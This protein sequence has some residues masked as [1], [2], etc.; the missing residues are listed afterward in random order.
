M[1]LA[2]D[3]GNSNIKL[4]LFDKS[5][6]KAQW[7]L[8]SSDLSQLAELV[9]KNLDAILIASVVPALNPT[10]TRISEEHFSLTPVF[11]DHT[12]PTGL[13]ILYDSPAELGADRIVDAVAAVA[14]YGAPCIVV[15]F[16]TATTFNA[17]NAAGEFLGGAISPGLMTCSEALF[18]RAAKLP[19]V[20]FERPAKVIGASTIASMQSGIYYGYTGLVDGMLERMIAE[21]NVKPRVIATGGLAHAIASR[22]IELRDDTLTLEGLRLVYERIKT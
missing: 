12:T 11:V 14:K 22:Y 21:M 8:T 17:I 2:I 5:E 9:P 20:N 7:R 13:K 16:G 19:R 6:L 10:L 15:D 3:A 4:A 1:L 18:A